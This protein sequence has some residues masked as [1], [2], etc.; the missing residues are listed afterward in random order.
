MPL[1]LRKNR[2]KPPPPRCA[3]GECM[4]LIGGAWT[5]NVIWHLSSGPRR[6]G[7]LRHDLAGVTAKV[8]SARLKSLEGKGVVRRS[9]KAT[10]PPSVEYSL[11]PLGEELVPAIQAIVEIGDR[12]KAGRGE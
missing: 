6:F 8:L 10:S 4:A 1:K 12:L 5:P 3:L 11:T 2:T 9:L 7:E